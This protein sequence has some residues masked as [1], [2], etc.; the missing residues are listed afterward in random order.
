MNELLGN[1]ASQKALY[2]YLTSG[3]K[4]KNYQKEDSS[5]K[6]EKIKNSKKIMWQIFPTQFLLI[7][8]S[9]QLQIYV[10]T[11]FFGT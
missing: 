8:Q 3:K 4:V 11:G 2:T 6:P 1:I 7:N 9:I 10:L 5:K